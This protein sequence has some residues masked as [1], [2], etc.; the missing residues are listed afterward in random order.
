MVA[1]CLAPRLQV[2]YFKPDPSPVGITKVNSV[3]T[4]SVSHLTNAVTLSLTIDVVRYNPT[5]PGAAQALH[6]AQGRG[7]WTNRA[8]TRANQWLV[9]GDLREISPYLIINLPRRVISRQP[10]SPDNYIPWMFDPSEETIK[11]S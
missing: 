8:Q 3:C 6:P 9:N 4:G 2:F 7:S 11:Q 10:S 1:I 5:A